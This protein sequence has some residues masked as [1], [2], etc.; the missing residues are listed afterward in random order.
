MYSFADC[1]LHGSRE[2]NVV[3]VN[4]LQIVHCTAFRDNNYF[5]VWTSSNPQNCTVHG[6]HSHVW[7]PWIYSSLSF[8]SSGM[9]P[10][11]SRE[12]K[13]FAFKMLLMHCPIPPWLTWAYLYLLVNRPW[14]TG[15]TPSRECLSASSWVPSPAPWELWRHN[16]SIDTWVNKGHNLGSGREIPHNFSQVPQENWALFTRSTN[17]LFYT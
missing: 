9:N 2:C 3:H 11:L 17:L 16:L 13:N 6:L 7:R 12:S 8:T 14:H 10:P 4:I 5:A 15:N 1:A